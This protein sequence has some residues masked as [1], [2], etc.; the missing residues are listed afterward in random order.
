MKLA[1][2]LLLLAELAASSHAQPFNVTAPP[3]EPK[4]GEQAQ[5]QGDNYSEYCCYWLTLC[6]CLLHDVSAS[7]VNYAVTNQ[8]SLYRAPSE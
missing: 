7:P 2:A 3:I 8:C 5:R 4:A 6:C 1:L